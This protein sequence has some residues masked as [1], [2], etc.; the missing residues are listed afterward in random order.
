MKL[1]VTP[2]R[3]LIAA[4]AASAA[5]GVPAAFATNPPT[6][7]SGSGIEAVRA[8]GAKGTQIIPN[9][10][11]TIGTVPVTVPAGSN[12]EIIVRFSADTACSGIASAGGNVNCRVRI[13]N[14]Q[15]TSSPYWD[16]ID[17]DNQGQKSQQ[18]LETH[19]ITRVIGPVPPGTYDL[20]ISAMAD[21]DV[22]YF[23]LANWHLTAVVVKGAS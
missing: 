12:G 22:T 3:A 2:T 10:W 11:T 23:A 8:A 19:M 6:V 7:V 17:E 16:G 14:T 5:V 9:T 1:R 20:T 18:S 4:A 13:E 21:V 15:Y